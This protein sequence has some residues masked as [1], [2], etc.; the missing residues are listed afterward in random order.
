[1]EQI[2][3]LNG[4]TDLRDWLAWGGD[5]DSLGEL[6]IRYPGDITTDGATDSDRHGT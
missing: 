5:E 2:L 1:M 4:L 3:A 6:G